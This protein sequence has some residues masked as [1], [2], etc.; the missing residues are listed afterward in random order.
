MKLFRA[1]P[2]K[3]QFIFAKYA[4]ERLAGLEA[5]DLYPIQPVKVHLSVQYTLGI[6]VPTV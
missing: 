2:S 5:A 6:I 4:L 3:I 1:N